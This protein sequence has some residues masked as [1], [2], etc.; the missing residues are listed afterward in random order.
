MLGAR[1]SFGEEEETCYFV[2]VI[3]S[4]LTYCHNCFNRNLQGQELHTLDNVEM[5]CTTTSY[6]NTAFDV[7]TLFDNHA[8]LCVKDVH[9]CQDVWVDNVQRWMG[10]ADVV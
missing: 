4:T 8:R 7:L 10:I 2:V 3:F 1:S 6:I 9:T 5:D